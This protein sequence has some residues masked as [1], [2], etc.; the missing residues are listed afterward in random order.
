MKRPS[1]VSL[2]SLNTMQATRGSGTGPELAL[3]SALRA[4]G[5]CGYRVNM[6][7][8]S[9]RPDVAFIRAKLAVFV[10]GCFWHRCP[11]CK[12][13]PPKRNEA[14]WRAKFEANVERDERTRDRLEKEGWSVL[15]FW[16]C[17][18]ERSAV[19]CAVRVQRWM[20]DWHESA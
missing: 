8:V 12:P 7:G 18:I 10:H 15:E 6:K 4:A 16:E 9:G 13:R 20:A 17:E 5:L 2:N 11:S 1:A 14:F 3:R 19:R